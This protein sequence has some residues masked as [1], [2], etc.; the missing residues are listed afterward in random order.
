MFGGLFGKKKDGPPAQAPAP[1]APG[2]SGSGGGGKPDARTAIAKTK[3]AIDVQTKRRDYIEHKMDLELKKAKQFQ[4]QNKKAD[5][6]MCMKRRKQLEQQKASVEATILKYNTSIIALENVLHAKETV[7][8]TALIGDALE[9]ETRAIGGADAADDVM[10]KL[11]DG[12][13]DVNELMGVVGRE[14][15]SGMDLG[16][17]DDLMAELD[18][19]AEESKEDELLSELTKDVDGIGLK[20]DPVPKSQP[21]PQAPTHQVSDEDAELAKLE[22]E[23]RM[24]ST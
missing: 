14:V 1:P 2:P 8:T 17:D 23:M 18:Q 12:M 10:A 21:M 6:I 9:N 5:A 7:Q 13:Q 4:A 22:A 3:E 16:D 19:L 15:D 11:E 24:G 20:A